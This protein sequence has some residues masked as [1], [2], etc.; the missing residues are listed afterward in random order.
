MRKNSF[1]GLRVHA[2]GTISCHNGSPRPRLALQL[3]FRHRGRIHAGVKVFAASAMMSAS[4]SDE[5]LSH[6]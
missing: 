3:S 1:G 5:L 4:E 2:N 6:A